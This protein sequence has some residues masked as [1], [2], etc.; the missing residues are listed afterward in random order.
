MAGAGPV[1]GRVMAGEGATGP[2][3]F[4]PAACPP[5]LISENYPEFSQYIL[6]S[7]DS[8]DASG[9]PL[10]GAER[11]LRTAKWHWRRHRAIPRGNPSPARPAWSPGA[12]GEPA[13]PARSPFKSQQ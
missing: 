13:S 9:F 2:Q 5:T 12:G 6:V 3:L 1:L 7:Y 10:L 4:L 11:V 8:P